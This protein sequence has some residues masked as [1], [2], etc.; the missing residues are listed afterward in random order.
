MLSLIKRLF[1]KY[2]WLY[3]P[4]EVRWCSKCRMFQGM[5]PLGM[6]GPD[7]G[8]TWKGDLINFTYKLL[9]LKDEERA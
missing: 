2:E 7:V 6:V 8:Y 1:H 5:D 3:E 9:E 4:Q